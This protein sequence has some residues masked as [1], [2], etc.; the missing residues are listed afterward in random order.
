MD[1][2]DKLQGYAARETRA[3]GLSVVVVSLPWLIQQSIIYVLP[4]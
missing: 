2:R 1:E 3:G 4:N